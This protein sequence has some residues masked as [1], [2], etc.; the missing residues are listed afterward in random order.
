MNDSEI[1]WHR[2]RVEENRALLENLEACNTAGRVAFPKALA[3]MERVK[4][5]IEKSQLIV[6]AY[7]KHHPDN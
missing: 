1:D 5:Q 4:A 3:E 6:A 2:R 7:E